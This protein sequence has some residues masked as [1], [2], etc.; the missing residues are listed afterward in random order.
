MRWCSDEMGRLCRHARAESP[1]HS[2]V[3]TQPLW[4]FTCVLLPRATAF[5]IGGGWGQDVDGRDK[6]IGPVAQ[7]DWNA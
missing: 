2:A 5:A 6:P 3:E 4:A 7:P 1:R